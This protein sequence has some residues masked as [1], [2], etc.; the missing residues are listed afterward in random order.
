M[1][2]ADNE[3]PW[4]D[5]KLTFFLLLALA[6]RVAA[7]ISCRAPARNSDTADSCCQV[8]QKIADLYAFLAQIACL[9]L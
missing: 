2:L 7:S 6:S 5:I 3:A 8:K 1:Q 9:T 4:A